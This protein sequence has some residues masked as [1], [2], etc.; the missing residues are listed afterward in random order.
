MILDS[1]KTTCIIK[2]EALTGTLTNPRGIRGLDGE[3][4]VTHLHHAEPCCLSS[5]RCCSLITL[6]DHLNHLASLP[7]SAQTG[8][9]IYANLPLDDFPSY[10]PPRTSNLWIS[11]PDV[12]GAELPPRSSR[13]PSQPRRAATRPP[14]RSPSRP[15][16]RP[17]WRLD[18]CC[19]AVQKAPV[20]LS[21][22]CDGNPIA[23]AK[24]MQK[25]CKIRIRIP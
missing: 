10:K 2:A 16:W 13:H 11:G 22:W 6:N 20:H 9:K 24:M 25:W 5:Q 17:K 1:E 4:L 12:S 7:S 23:M 18:R 8:H 21:A 19:S 14:L 15:K 3:G